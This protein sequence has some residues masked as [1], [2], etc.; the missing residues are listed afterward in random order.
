[1][2][3]LHCAVHL[4]M[5]SYGPKLQ[6]ILFQISRNQGVPGNASKVSKADLVLL[7][8]FWTCQTLIEMI[9]IHLGK[10]KEF[11]NRKWC[12]SGTM[13]VLNHLLFFF[14]GG[15]GEGWAHLTSQVCMVYPR[16]MKPL[17][18]QHNSIILIG[19]NSEW[20][21]YFQLRIYKYHPFWGTRSLKANT[22]CSCN[23][24]WN[25]L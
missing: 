19:F 13:S 24:W 9:W 5:A 21:I 7:L 6:L 3:Y 1:M 12:S 4:P 8:D 16:M 15:G 25:Q 22:L 23:S 18:L 10:L 14:A 17:A 11:I 2:A 20:F